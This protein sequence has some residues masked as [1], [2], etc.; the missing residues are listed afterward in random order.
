M[1][2]SFLDTNVLV[3]ADDKLAGQKQAKAQ[4]LIEEALRTGNGVV[5]T[6]VL[7]EYFA[8][9]TRKLGVPPEAA[10]L[11]VE[12]YAPLTA[13]TIDV[14]HI[15]QAIKLH[16]LHQI[17]FWDALI[18]HAANRSGC[19][20]LLTEDLQVGRIIEG[21]EIVNPFQTGKLSDKAAASGYSPST[22]KQKARRRSGKLVGKEI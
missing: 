1:S 5:S 17:N 4:D 18:V 14:E 12:T 20:R 11:R 22:K 19:S 7:Q 8:V 6:Q 15:L 13:V 10:Q 16:R 9:T 2:R 21:V 3:Y